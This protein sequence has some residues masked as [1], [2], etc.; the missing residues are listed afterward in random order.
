M[1][2]PYE[3]DRTIGPDAARTRET[4]GGPSGHLRPSDGA[5]PGQDLPTPAQVKT[6]ADEAG[7]VNERMQGGAGVES[8]VPV[9]TGDETIEELRRKLHLAERNPAECVSLRRQLAAALQ[10]MARWEEALSNLEDASRLAER[11]GLK[12]ESAFIAIEFGKIAMVRGD[13]DRALEC[14]AR[15]IALANGIVAAGGVEEPLVL[16]FAENL[17]G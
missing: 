6:S 3:G 16:G 14:S 11:H 12:A 15:A 10:A 2:S 1:A 13:I 5:L 9:R 4:S 7:T 8:V 17:R